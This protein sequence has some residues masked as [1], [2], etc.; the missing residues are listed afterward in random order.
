V[1]GQG[2]W[3]LMFDL[4]APPNATVDLRVFLRRGGEALTE[5][6]MYEVRT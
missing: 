1:V 6:W 2:A 4:D 3:R 5:T